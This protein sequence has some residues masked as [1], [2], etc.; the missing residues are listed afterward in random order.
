[1]GNL[2]RLKELGFRI[3]VGGQIIKAAEA[4]SLS[5]STLLVE[6]AEK[7]AAGIVEKAEQH[8]EEEKARGYREGLANAAMEAVNRLLDEEAVL[9]TSLVSID[10]DL[11]D[12]VLACVRKIIGKFDDHALARA[13]IGNAVRQMRR[14]KRIRLSISSE[15]YGNIKEHIAAMAADFTEIDSIDV[16]ES[17]SLTGTQFIMESEIGRIDGSVAENLDDLGAQ[18]KTAMQNYLVKIRNFKSSD[19]AI[20]LISGKSTETN[21]PLL[22]FADQQAEKSTEMA[23]ADEIVSNAPASK[24]IKADGRKED[25]LLPD[26]DVVNPSKIDDESGEAAKP[27]AAGRKSR[28][29]DKTSEAADTKTARPRRKPAARK[30]AADKPAEIEENPKRRKRKTVAELLNAKPRQSDNGGAEG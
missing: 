8:Y 10:E 3:P 14:Q 5:V 7:K 1:V 24:T 9:E 12:I 29:K 26:S 11:A 21:N 4:E 16:V 27:V 22:S 15:Q 17:L 2:Y 18:L 23:T 30:R 6:E 20:D 28:L 25:A 19:D 13:Y